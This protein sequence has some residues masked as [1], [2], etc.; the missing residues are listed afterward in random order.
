M[1]KSYRLIF[2]EALGI[3]QVAPETSKAK[4]KGSKAKVEP[5]VKLKR[6]SV[7]VIATLM[8]GAFPPP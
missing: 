1:N 7:S 6:R 8:L 2:N 4:G 5:I 3:F